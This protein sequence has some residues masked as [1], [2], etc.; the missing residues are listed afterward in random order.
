MEPHHDFTT[1]KQMPSARMQV[2]VLSSGKTGNDR[3]WTLRFSNGSGQLAFF[4]NPQL[5]KGGEEVLPSFWSDNYFSV[6]AGGSVTVTVSCPEAIL[7]KMGASQQNGAGLAF[8]GDPSHDGG[9]P[10]LK[11]EGWNV[12]EQWTQL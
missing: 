11:L 5:I 4:L 8:G 10:R 7:K 2:K 6:P 3:S 9:S 1:L 12:P